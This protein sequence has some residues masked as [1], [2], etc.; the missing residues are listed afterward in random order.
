[1]LT[2]TCKVSHVV[3]GCFAIF[4]GGLHSLTLGWIC[5]DTHAHTHTHTRILYTYI[6]PWHQVWTCT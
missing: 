4:L 6:K 3:L 2:A 5:W 1:M